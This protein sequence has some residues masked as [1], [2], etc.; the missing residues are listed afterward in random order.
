ML[1]GAVVFS[2]GECYLWL[3]DIRHIEQQPLKPVAN[4]E[5]GIVVYRGMYGQSTDDYKR[6]MGRLPDDRIAEPPAKRRQ[7]SSFARSDNN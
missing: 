1:A 7:V 6:R 4:D 2:G 5:P 3:A